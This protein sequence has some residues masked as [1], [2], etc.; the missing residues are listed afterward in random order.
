MLKIRWF[1]KRRISLAMWWIERKKTIFVAL[2]FPN[3]SPWSPTGQKNHLKKIKRNHRDICALECISITIHSCDSWLSAWF[4]VPF[5]RIAHRIIKSPKWIALHIY[6]SSTT[7]PFEFFSI[8]VA[9]NSAFAQS[10]SSEWFTC[11]LSNHILMGFIKA[12]NL[13][14]SRW[15]SP[16]R[17]E[18][19]SFINSCPPPLRP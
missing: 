1:T 5:I 2:T 4:Q 8:W 16:F 14:V 9:I 18:M 7:H 3:P 15:L 13:C 19:I 11:F 17:I 6:W 12:T 10:H